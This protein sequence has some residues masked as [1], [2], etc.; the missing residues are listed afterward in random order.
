MVSGA[1]CRIYSYDFWQEARLSLEQQKSDLFMLAEWEDPALMNS[2]NMD[3]G[4][5]LHHIMN[6]VA[7]EEMNANDIRE[8]HTEMTEKY[9]RDDIRMFFT[10]N[11]DENSCRDSVTNG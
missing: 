2:F 8:Y 10:T 4:W 6:K 7:V 11:H 9:S 3:Y 5:H 1:M